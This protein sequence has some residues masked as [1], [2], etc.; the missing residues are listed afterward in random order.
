M[1]TPHRSRRRRR[2]RCR[3][4]TASRGCRR[5]CSAGST[6]MLYDKR[7]AG[8]DVIDLGMGNPSDP[9]QEIG[10]REAGR[11][12]PR[13]RQPRLLER[14]R[15]RQPAPRGGR[16]VLPQVRRAARSRERGDRLPR[17]EGGLQ[18]H[19]PGP[20]GAGRHGDR[21]GAVLSD[22]RLRDRAGVGATSSR[23]KW[24]TATSSSR[25]SPTPASTSTRGRSCW[26]STT[27]TIRRA[28]SSSRSSSTRW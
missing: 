22:P 21:P 19:V 3:S 7:R 8:E 10:H 16:Q 9:P 27:R 14:Q 13:H 25:T 12:G 17:L 2:S 23:W 6:R 11:G 20:D 26:S 4:P 18:P 24:P 5:T 15:H 1:T 28:S